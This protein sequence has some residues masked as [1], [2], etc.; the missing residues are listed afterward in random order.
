MCQ[1]NKTL[2]D[3]QFLRT[4]RFYFSTPEELSQAGK[5]A[6]YYIS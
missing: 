5:G 1:K 2:D 3:N 4:K 6:D